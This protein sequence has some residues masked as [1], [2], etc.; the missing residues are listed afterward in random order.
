MAFILRRTDQG[1][2]YVAEPGSEKSYTHV[3]RK[4]RRFA[5]EE[6]AEAE[7]CGNEAIERY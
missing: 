3:R 2:G 4:A 6:A 7:R 1:G 5:S